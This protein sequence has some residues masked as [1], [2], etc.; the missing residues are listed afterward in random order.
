MPTLVL[1]PRYT[2][3]SAA[4]G[5]AA[6]RAG[7]E[8]E[9]LPTWRVPDHLSGRDVVLYA[10]PLFAAVVAEDLDLSLMEPPHDWLARLPREYTLREVRFTTLA[11]A[12]QMQ[13]AAFVKPAE[14]KCFPAG[15]SSSGG[16]LPGDEVL[17][18]TTPVLLSEPVEWEVEFRCFCLD[19]R[20]LT[21]SPYWRDGRTAQADDGSWPASAEELERARELAS[22]VLADPRTSLPPAVV[23][24]VGVVRG[25]GWAVVEANSAWGSGVYGCDP[26]AV[27][28]VVRR[29]C[30]RVASAR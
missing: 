5:D 12:R 16:D 3:D 8:V 20:V 29:A 23:V 4:V 13:A 10:E 18:G 24:D 19:G 26:D 17:P 1:P 6:R 11:E 14:E 7:W 28:Q 25:R 22:A 15:V 9:R 27:L 21:L 2:P 30:V